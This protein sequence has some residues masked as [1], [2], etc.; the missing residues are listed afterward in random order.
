[1][2]PW[3]ENLKKWANMKNGA[4][5][6]SLRNLTRHQEWSGFG[7]VPCLEEVQSSSIQ[8][9]NMAERIWF[10]QKMANCF[11]L[12]TADLE[13]NTGITGVPFGRTEVSIRVLFFRE[14]SFLYWFAVNL[15]MWNLLVQ[16]RITVSFSPYE[17]GLTMETKGPLHVKVLT[18]LTRTEVSHGVRIA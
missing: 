16:T 15:Y 3:S 14:I 8:C 9:K 7:R 11:F 13:R 2:V 17:L 4:T 5:R 12:L 10:G 1:M 18:L 6:E